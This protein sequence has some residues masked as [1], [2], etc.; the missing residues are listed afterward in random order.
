LIK[1]KIEVLRK[2]QRGLVIRGHIPKIDHLKYF[3]L[4]GISKDSKTAYNLLINSEPSVLIITNPTIRNLEVEILPGTY[5]FLKKPT[6]SYINCLKYYKVDSFDL[7]NGL[8]DNPS[9]IC[10]YLTPK[11]LWQVVQAV[12]NNRSFNSEERNIVTV[13]LILPSRLCPAIR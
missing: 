3:I 7:I 8:I 10:G 12:E 6:P 11:H 4:V 9:K 1:K 13:P 5:Q 2:I